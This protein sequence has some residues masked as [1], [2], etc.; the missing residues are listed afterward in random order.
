LNSWRKI[1]HRLTAPVCQLCG[2]AGVGPDICRGCFR[3]LPRPARTCQRCARP[4]SGGD[5]CG[6]CRIA[7]P[8][9]DAAFSAFLYAF[10]VD[11]MVMSLKYDGYLSRARLLGE[12]L[13][14]AVRRRPRPDVMVPVPLHRRRWR[15]RG[16]NQARELAVA[17]R[18]VSGAP[19]LEGACVRVRD[20]P[21]LWDL[22]PSQRRRQVRGAFRIR[23]DLR[24]LYVALID[25][26]LTTGT[27]AD[28]LSRALR[29][30]GVARVEIWT[31]A[32]A[33]AQAPAKR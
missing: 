1:V 31:V 16:F 32:R 13:G 24:G 33:A 12:L 30:R 26:V 19:L 6:G 2:A 29:C 11:R 22:T 5:V 8:D 7:P 15:Q 14:H 28:A 23:G 25:D 21:P 17:V 20:T 10:P 27:T 4:L 9:F 18:R 3:D